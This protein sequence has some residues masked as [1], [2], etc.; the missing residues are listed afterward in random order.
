MMLAAKIGFKTP[1][2]TS[3]PVLKILYH[4]NDPAFLLQGNHLAQKC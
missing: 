4:T 2:T 3:I 1:L